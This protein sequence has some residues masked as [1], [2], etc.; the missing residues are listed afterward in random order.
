M[1]PPTVEQIVEKHRFLA[2]SEGHSAVKAAV[3]SAQDKVA[4]EHRVR[5]GIVFD[6]WPFRLD[7]SYEYQCWLLIIV[8]GVCMTLCSLPCICGTFKNPV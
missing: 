5:Q 8:T 7:I 1:A 3:E 6:R 2:Q 4:E